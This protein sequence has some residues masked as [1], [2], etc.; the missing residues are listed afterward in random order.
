M[1]FG[2]RWQRVQTYAS[3][4]AW[5]TMA[6][7]ED[8]EFTFKDFPETAV[9]GMQLGLIWSPQIALGLGMS[10]TPLN[11]V[12]GAALA[13]LGI[14][15]AIGGRE[16]AETYIDYITDPGD[17][18]KNPQKAE[19]LM[20]ANRIV[21]AGVTLGGSELARAGVNVLKDF[22]N[23]IFKNRFVTGPYLPF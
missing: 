14:S 2:T 11:I 20:Q 9:L 23:E 10:A 3:L 13:G 19:A 17:I 22:K 12:E 5:Y 4:G 18:V 21:M 15:Y 1:Q 6:I 8:G 7:H 16:G